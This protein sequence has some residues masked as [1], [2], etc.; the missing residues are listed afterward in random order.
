M[1]IFLYDFKGKVCYKC[2]ILHSRGGAHGWV[3]WLVIRT[4][5]ILLLNGLPMIEVIALL[6]QTGLE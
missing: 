3:I 5:Y 6:D 2:Q 4:A 1:E